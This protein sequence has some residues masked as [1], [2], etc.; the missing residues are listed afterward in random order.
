[1]P[2]DKAVALQEYAKQKDRICPQPQAWNQLWRL[3]PDRVQKPSGG[4]SP[5]LPLILAAW[6]DSSV[7]EKARRLHDHIEWADERG[8]IDAVDDYLRG[9]SEQEWFH[10]SD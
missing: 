3:L 1:M 6:Y 10:G 5:S 4:W 9:L 7:L 8:A 2:S